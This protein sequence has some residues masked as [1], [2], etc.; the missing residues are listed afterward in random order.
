MYIDGTSKLEKELDIL[1]ILRDF[2][3]LK[4]YLN[5]KMKDPKIK[6]TIQN[7]QKHFIIIDSSDQN[8]KV[9]D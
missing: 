9:Q 5:D 7:S 8:E 6:Y 3:N 4:C 2:R 1:A